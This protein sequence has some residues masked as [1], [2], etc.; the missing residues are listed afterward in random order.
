MAAGG[1]YFGGIFGAPQQVKDH[2]DSFEPFPTL[3]GLS[4]LLLVLFVVVGRRCS[5]QT[6]GRRGGGVEGER[7]RERNR[8]R[9]LNLIS[10]LR[11]KEEEGKEAQKEVDEIP[12]LR[13]IFSFW[14][15][16]LSRSLFSSFKSCAKATASRMS[17]SCWVFLT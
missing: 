3:P 14:A 2:A 16:F 9:R 7:E 15:L 11:S 4:L 13:S 8:R 17:S 10:A 6:R 1:F 12:V 5:G